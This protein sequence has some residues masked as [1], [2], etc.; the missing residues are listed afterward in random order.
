MRR[1]ALGVSLLLA[2][3]H[4]AVAAAAGFAAL[5]SPPRFELTG[6]SGTTVRQVFELTNR[7]AG[8]AKFHVH[9]ADFTL[10]A[11]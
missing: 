9:T 11:H 10:G 8:P 7:S 1:M 3:W 5:V 2:S 6:R 4:V